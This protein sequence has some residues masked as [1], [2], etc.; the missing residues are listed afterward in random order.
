MFR[1]YLVYA[2]VTI[3]SAIIFHA[4]FKK[5]AWYQKSFGKVVNW[6]HLKAEAVKTWATKSDKVVDKAEKP[7]KA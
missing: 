1:K 4:C 2:L 6:F 3:A 5:Y 7:A